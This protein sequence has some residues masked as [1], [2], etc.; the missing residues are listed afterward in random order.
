MARIVP[1]DNK[2]I[3]LSQGIFCQISGHFRTVSLV[4][5]LDADGILWPDRLAA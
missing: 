3:A 4:L 2:A 5:L 1:Y